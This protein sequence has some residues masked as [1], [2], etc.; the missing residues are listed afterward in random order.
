MICSP[1]NWTGPR[2][3]L[4]SSETH[5]YSYALVLFTWSL[6]NFMHIYIYLC[7]RIR[8][9]ASLEYLGVRQST[10]LCHSCSVVLANVRANWCA[11]RL[12][13]A[14]GQLCFAWTETM[15]LHAYV[16]SLHPSAKKR[17]DNAVVRGRRVHGCY[18][19]AETT[20]KWQRDA[21]VLCMSRLGAVYLTHTRAHTHT[22]HTCFR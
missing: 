12:Y 11:T 22:P 14:D 10:H 9:F 5:I 21:G 8:L 17:R 18:A 6:D 7:W 4:T 2:V 16:T 13:V 1:P 19:W 20:A 15:T 3:D